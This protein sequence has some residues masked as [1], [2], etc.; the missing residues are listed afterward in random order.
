[1]VDLY[2]NSPHESVPHGGAQFRGFI[3]MTVHFDEWP[4]TH[5]YVRGKQTVHQC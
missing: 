4:T 5:L 1:M 3:N 2:C